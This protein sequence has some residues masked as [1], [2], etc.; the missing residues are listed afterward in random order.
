MGINELGR[1][2][3][4]SHFP[5]LQRNPCTAGLYSILQLCA[6]QG[7]I[8]YCC[9]WAH[10]PIREQQTESCSCSFTCAAGTKCV[11]VCVDAIF[12]S[13]CYLHYVEREHPSSFHRRTQ[14]EKTTSRS[15]A[16]CSTL[17]AA[18][19]QQRLI[20][21]ART[22]TKLLRCT[23]I[24]RVWATIMTERLY[25]WYDLSRLTVCDSN[26]VELMDRHIVINKTYYVVPPA[27]LFRFLGGVT[28]IYTYI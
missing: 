14:S 9:S 7:R 10:R 27:T 3:V 21:R 15:S 23:I 22:S 11:H 12:K 1:K 17:L 26:V 8:T 18:V 4:S 13:P 5:R 19:L 2:R 25:R 28:C 6:L 20:N 24:R 16:S